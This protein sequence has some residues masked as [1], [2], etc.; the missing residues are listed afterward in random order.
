M[1]ISRPADQIEST[2]E[3]GASILLR[4]VLPEDKWRFVEG[5]TRLSPAARFQRFFSPI[6]RLTEEQLE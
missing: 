3:A 5:F 4:R 6:K 1:I 2:S